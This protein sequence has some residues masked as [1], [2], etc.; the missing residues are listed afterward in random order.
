M[1]LFELK[2]QYHQAEKVWKSK[3]F[4]IISDTKQM[5]SRQF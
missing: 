5:T 3:E 1:K 4:K 2:K